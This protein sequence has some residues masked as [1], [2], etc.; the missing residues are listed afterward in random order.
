MNRTRVL[1]ALAALAGWLC[2]AHAGAAADDKKDSDD[3]D[4][5]MKASAAG[6][7]EVNL[8][9][10]AARLGNNPAVKEFAQRMIVDHGKANK[11]LLALANTKGF[12]PAKKMDAKHQEMLGK[13][14]KMEG[15]AFDR[16][17]MEGMVKDHE[18]AVKL[19]ETQSKE[20]QDKALKGWAGEKLPTLKMHLKMAKDVANTVKGKSER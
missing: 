1:V 11:E 7:A 13:L 16:A 20:G 15:A 2:L 3:N 8:S 6:L 10:L 9:E 4:F 17:Y 12:T 19:F 14:S 5:V 18:E